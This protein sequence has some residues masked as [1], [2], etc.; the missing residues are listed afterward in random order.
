M[1]LQVKAL[2]SEAALQVPAGPAVPAEEP[3]TWCMSLTALMLLFPLHED[4][5]RIIRSE[6]LTYR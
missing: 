6:L 2:Q 3:S 5:P 4:A 1:H